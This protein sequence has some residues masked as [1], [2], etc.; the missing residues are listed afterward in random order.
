MNK[1]NRGEHSGQARISFKD[2]ADAPAYEKKSLWG[3]FR[4]SGKYRLE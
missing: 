2:G 4:Y 3:S 1:S